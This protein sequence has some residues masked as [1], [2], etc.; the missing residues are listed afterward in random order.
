MLDRL[1]EKIL[2]FRDLRDWKQFHD[3]KNLAEAIVIESGELLENFLWRTCDEC[4]K[5]PEEMFGDIG[6]E[7]ADI[8]I[9]LTILAHELKLDIETIVNRK[10]ELNEEKYPVETSRGKAGKHH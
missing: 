3:P 4:R 1:R 10:L 8:A 2:Q 6:E 9:F 7:I 5:P